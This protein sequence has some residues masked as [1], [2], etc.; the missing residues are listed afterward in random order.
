MKPKRVT[1]IKIWKERNKC[2]ECEGD[3]GGGF[4]L[5]NRNGYL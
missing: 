2:G 3:K 1:K 5:G 4:E